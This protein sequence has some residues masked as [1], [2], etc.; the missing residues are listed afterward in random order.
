METRSVKFREWLAIAL[1]ALGIIGADKLKEWF[2]EIVPALRWLVAP[3]TLPWPVLIAAVGVVS[4]VA[5]RIGSRRSSVKADNSIQAAQAARSSPAEQPL[6][7]EA[8]AASTTN[9]E[10]PNWAYSPNIVEKDVLRVLRWGDDWMGTDRVRKWLDGEAKN[11]SMIELDL[12]LQRLH[13]E[14]WIDREY[15]RLGTSNGHYVYKL[16]RRGMDFSVAAGFP[17]SRTTT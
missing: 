3:V 2:A 1:A 16:T 6:P 5:F 4:F 8:P 15:R 10:K 7:E 14:R 9:A 11:A 17:H 13:S 12:A